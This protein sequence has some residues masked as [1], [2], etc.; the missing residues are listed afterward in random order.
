M[1]L[2]LP[3]IY[4]KIQCSPCSFECQV[5]WGREMSLIA[6]HWIL[7]VFN[8]A[9]DIASTNI[10]SINSSY[11]IW[12][13]LSTFTNTQ[14]FSGLQAKL[15]TEKLDTQAVLRKVLWKVLML[16]PLRWYQSVINFISGRKNSFQLWYIKKVSSC[17]IQ[18]YELLSFRKFEMPSIVRLTIILLLLRKKMKIL[19]DAF[20]SFKILYILFI[21]NAFWLFKWCYV[22]WYKAKYSYMWN[23]LVM[24]F[25]KPLHI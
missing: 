20:L 5:W 15:T 22:H 11:L 18:I 14:L 10:C 3:N 9:W 25:L 19:H 8:R 24:I 23:T 7:R 6:H 13:V 21:N 16:S 17:F 4:L 12:R 1:W 2:N